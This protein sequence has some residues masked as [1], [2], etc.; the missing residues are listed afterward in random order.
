M[1][2]CMKMGISSKMEVCSW[3]RQKVIDKAR[4]HGWYKLFSK[5]ISGAVDGAA[6]LS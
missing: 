5:P 6:V 2:L 1:Y 3:D 4:E